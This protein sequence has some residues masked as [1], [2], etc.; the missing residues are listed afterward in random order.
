MK[1]I[2]MDRQ[3]TTLYDRPLSLETSE[4]LE[5]V[6]STPLEEARNLTTGV[7]ILVHIPCHRC[8]SNGRELLQQGLADSRSLRRTRS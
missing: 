3:S 1:E 7:P 8:G 4:L 5:N 6:T 2:A